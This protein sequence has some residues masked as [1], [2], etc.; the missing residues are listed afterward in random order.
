MLAPEPRSHRRVPDG[1]TDNDPEMAQSVTDKDAAPLAP[2]SLT[3]DVYL[4]AGY[5]R[6]QLLHGINPYIHN[7]GQLAAAGE[8]QARFLGPSGYGPVWT[9]LALAICAPLSAAGLWWQ[10]A[11]L[12]LLEA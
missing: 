12:K 11:A 1:R 3:P 6:I 10:V 4:Y 8:P 5:A 7:F 9:L 2:P